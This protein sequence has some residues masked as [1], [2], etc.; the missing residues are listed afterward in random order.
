MK[1]HVIKENNVYR[2]RP[3]CGESSD[4]EALECDIM[5]DAFAIVASMN[6]DHPIGWAV[7]D[8]LTKQKVDKNSL[9]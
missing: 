6:K 9:I 8:S 3:Y 4:N 1:Y 7:Y 2:G 5:Y